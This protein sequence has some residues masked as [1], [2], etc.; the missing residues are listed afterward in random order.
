LPYASCFS[1]AYTFLFPVLS[2]EERGVC[3][4]VMRERGREMY[5]HLCPRHLAHPYDSHSN[6]AWHFLGEIGLAF[7]GEIPEAADWVWFA[8][9]VF[10]CAYPVWSDDDGGWHEGLAYWRS[11]V[12]LFTGW[13]DV[14]KAALGLDAYRLPYFSRA[15]Y[16]PLYLQPP[17]Q[18][19]GGF[20]DLCEALDSKGNAPL[21][22]ILA[23]A[24]RNSHWQ[25]YAEANGGAPPEPGFVGFLR[26]SQPAVPGKAPADLPSSRLFRGTGLAVLNL[27]VLD[28]SKNVQVLLKASPFGTQSHGYDAQN[29]FQLNV[30]GEPLLVSSGSRDMYASEHHRDWMWETKSVNSVTVC[31]RGQVKHSRVARGEIAEFRAGPVLDYA[32]GE[33]AGAYGGRLEAFTRRI[34]FVKPDLVVLFDTIRAPVPS[35]YEWRFHAN[36]PFAAGPADFAVE[37]KAGAARVSLLAP[38]GLRLEQTD[39]FDPPP[40]PRVVLKQWHLT[41]STT[42]PAMATAFVAVIRT[43]RKGEPFPDPLEARRMEG[44]FVLRGRTPA[45][46]VV[47]LLRTGKGELAEDTLGTEQRVAAWVLDDQGGEVVS[48]ESEEGLEEGF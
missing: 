43:C 25:W 34:L 27:T 14:M 33:A 20:G 6:R 42:E 45:G 35:A 13:A 44:G 16:F 4:A 23:A 3:R 18:R 9:N 39:R 7:L 12:G 30:A 32:A 19:G 8:A 2:E 48:F 11:Y 26:G 21:M 46:T 22:A 36:A 17:G 24:A 40:R 38:A 41:A 1:R 47:V 37:G 15:G 10:R 29:A 28:A 5:N 31:G